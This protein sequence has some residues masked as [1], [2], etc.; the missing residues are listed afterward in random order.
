M[1]A[2][3]SRESDRARGR[4]NLERLALAVTSVGAHAQV[5]PDQPED[6]LSWTM[7]GG[8]RWH[9]TW[10]AGGRIAIETATT[11]PEVLYLTAVRP[12]T[13]VWLA[14]GGMYCMEC[15]AFISDQ[16]VA[17]MTLWLPPRYCPNCGRRITE[18]RKR[19]G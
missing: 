8:Q 7:P 2:A 4:A 18:Q 12:T 13:A 19:H 10:V 9:A 14:E 16:A 3:A 6:F 5:R 1:S 15:W 11:W 17:D